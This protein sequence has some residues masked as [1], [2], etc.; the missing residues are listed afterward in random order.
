[1]RVKTRELRRC[2]E[3]SG[4]ILTIVLCE[5]ARVND[6]EVPACSKNQAFVDPV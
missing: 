1:M 6:M 3:L 5:V 4:I 2:L